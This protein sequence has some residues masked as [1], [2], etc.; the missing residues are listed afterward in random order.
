VT[1][2]AAFLAAAALAGVATFLAATRG[3]AVLD[4]RDT[5]TAA[6]N[7]RRPPRRRTVAA[8]GMSGAGRPFPPVG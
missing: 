1:R 4:G 2:L 3:A 7:A 8:V 5:A 6:T